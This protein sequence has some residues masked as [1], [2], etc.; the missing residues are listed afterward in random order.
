MSCLIPATWPTGKDIAVIHYHR[1]LQL[2]TRPRGCL[3]AHP[4]T[5][6]VSMALARSW[7]LPSY[8]LGRPGAPG[9]WRLPARPPSR[10]GAPTRGIAP[11]MPYLLLTFGQSTRPRGPADHRNRGSA[12]RFGPASRR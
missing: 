5:L 6:A 9:R 8:A 10:H 7:A 11:S 12:F 1:D 3:A 4:A 2:S